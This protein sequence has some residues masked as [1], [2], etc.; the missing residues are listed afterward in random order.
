MSFFFVPG[1]RVATFHRL[2]EPQILGLILT[3][4]IIIGSFL[5]WRIAVAI[6][7]ISIYSTIQ[8]F[9]TALA[10]DT[11]G[12]TLKYINPLS[13]ISITSEVLL[14]LCGLLIFGIM[15]YRWFDKHKT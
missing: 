10:L 14:R 5:R 9:I 12:V 4:I 6:N 3:L 7:V 15:I 1:N 13:D 11:G 8:Y 2:I